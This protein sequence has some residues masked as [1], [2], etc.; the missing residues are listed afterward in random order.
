M[1]TE[2]VFVSSVGV[3][4]C[5]Q[6]KILLNKCIFKAFQDS[7]KSFTQEPI[8]IESAETNLKFISVA[9]LTWVHCQ[10]FASVHMNS[11][12]DVHSDLNFT[13]AI[14]TEVKFQTREFLM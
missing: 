3:P 1:F 9:N 11:G 2:Q 14:L 8:V 10:L 4:K 5:C 12:S 13:L 7:K 6:M